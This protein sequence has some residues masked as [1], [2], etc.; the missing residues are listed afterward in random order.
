MLA[1]KARGWATRWLHGTAGL[2]ARVGISPNQLTVAGFAAVLIGGALIGAGYLQWAG[3]WLLL[4][5][6]LDAVDG[7]LARR[8]GQVTAFGAFLDATLDRYAEVVLYLGLLVYFLSRHN[9]A[10]VYLVYVAI[11][12]SLLISYARAKAESVGI[13]L[14]EGF[15]TRF[16]RLALLVMGLL[17]QR[18][19]LALWLL[20]PLTHVTAAQRVWVVW[21]RGRDIA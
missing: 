1:E 12:G 10:A 7:T 3:V 15:L 13:P 19:E 4:T 20:A 8:T 2:L 14:K 6:W 5:A 9:E 21:T 11:T 18:V 16:E 17:L